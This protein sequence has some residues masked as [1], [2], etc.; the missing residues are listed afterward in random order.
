M[1]SK[2]TGKQRTGYW[3]LVLRSFQTLSAGPVSDLV[4]TYLSGCFFDHYLVPFQRMLFVAYR[5][6]DTT[7]P[8]LRDLAGQ[9]TII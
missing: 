3:G 4:Q 2:G 7:P 6:R 9:M 5:T 8:V 1:P